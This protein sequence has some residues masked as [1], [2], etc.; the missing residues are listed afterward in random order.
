MEIK[1]VAGVSPIVRN[2]DA[3]VAFYRDTLKVPVQ[4]NEQNPHYFATD[5][6]DGLKH[7]GLWRLEDAAE[8]CF[9]TREW[10]AELP[11]PQATVEFDVDDVDAAAREMEAAGYTLVHDTRTEPWGQVVARV[12]SPEG[13]LIGLTYTPWMRE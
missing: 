2:V 9:G 4:S 12:L 3:S 10:P 8:S 5:D 11:V 13:L 1:F 7:M 6:V